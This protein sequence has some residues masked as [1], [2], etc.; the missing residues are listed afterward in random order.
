MLHLRITNA[1]FFPYP[2]Y[3]WE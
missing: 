3:K 1:A 2:G